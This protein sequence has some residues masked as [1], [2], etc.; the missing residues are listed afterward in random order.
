[1]TDKKYEIIYADPPWQFSN[2]KTGGSMKAGAA[3]HYM[4]T[5]IEGLK[6]LDVN[7]IAADDCA[8]LL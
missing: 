1:M 8:F 4:T 3:H 7:S 6:A 2:K 5:G